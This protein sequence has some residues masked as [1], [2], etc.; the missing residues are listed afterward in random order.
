M[1]ITAIDAN[2]LLQTCLNCRA[3]HRIPIKQ[4]CTKSRKG[5][6]ALVDGD[7]LEL[8]VDDQATPQVITFSS[9]DFA[10][11]GTAE[12]TEV[13]AKLGTLL[14][15]G[16]ADV[17]DGAVRIVSN[18]VGPATSSIEVIGG[19]ARA[20]LGL[21][22]RKRASLRLGVTK[23]IGVEAQTAV[24]TI[25]LPQCPDCGANES[26]VRTW[27]RTPP[28][29]ANSFHARHRRAV[30]AL[31]QYLKA[32]GYSDANAKPIHD[33][34]AATPS[35]LEASFPTRRIDLP[36]PPS[37]QPGASDAGEQ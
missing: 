2:E 1:P 33:A 34:E 37:L 3:T 9:S 14:A 4:G 22:G 29:F 28:G 8:R 31:A 18:G 20:K 21:D 36:A 6:Y 15:G 23:G 10:D 13:V 24:D 11:I 25:D 19:S 12:A 5:P 35:D 27:D 7:T 16:S 32:E 26:L 17:D 30:N